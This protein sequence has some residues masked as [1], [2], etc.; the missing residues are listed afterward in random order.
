MRTKAVAFS[1]PLLLAAGN[2]QS[3]AQSLE[4]ERAAVSWP[5]RLDRAEDVR[6]AGPPVTRSEDCPQLGRAI[7][8]GAGFTIG[9]V[10]GGALGRAMSSDNPIGAVTQIFTGAIV[11]GFIGLIL[12]EQIGRSVDCDRARRRERMAEQCGCAPLPLR[13]P[14]T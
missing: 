14:S 13:L 1:L 6:T 5:S 2:V 11:G 8:G 12:G 3:A 10:A 9:L 7:G 4:A